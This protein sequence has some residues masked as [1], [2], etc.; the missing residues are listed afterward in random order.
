MLRQLLATAILALALPLAR[1][2]VAGTI[3]FVAGQVNIAARPAV[4]NSPVNEGELISTGGDGYIYIK[5]IDGGLFIVRPKSEA[6]IATYH[7]D[8]VNP[9]NTVVKLEL[10]RGVARSQSGDAVKQARQNFRFN[11]PVAAIGVRG[12]DFTVFTDH[13]TS[14]VTVLTGRITISGFGEGCHPEGRGPCE[15]I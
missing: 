11:T 6:R 15:G 8:R 5:T 9:A 3:I 13:E 14:R 12:T 2:D 4:L 7:V 10:L 1:A